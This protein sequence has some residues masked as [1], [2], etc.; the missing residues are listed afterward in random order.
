M[1]DAVYDQWNSPF[2]KAIR[3]MN[4]EH[5]AAKPVTVRTEVRCKS[6]GDSSTASEKCLSRFQRRQNAL[7]SSLLFCEDLIKIHGTCHTVLRQHYKSKLKPY[8]SKIIS[9]L[10]ITY[11]TTVSYGSNDL[12]L[13]DRYISVKVIP[14]PD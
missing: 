3:P 14:M 12:C 7:D 1:V 10:I 2:I 6:C 13:T 11:K 8:S 5:L 9:S 4:G